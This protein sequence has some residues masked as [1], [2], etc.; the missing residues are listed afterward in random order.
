MMPKATP[1]E[2]LRSRKF[3]GEGEGRSGDT[4]SGEFEGRLE[5][6]AGGLW[7]S[8]IGQYQRDESFP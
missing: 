6:S 2:S 7:G 5:L 4:E 1:I 8:G 3:C